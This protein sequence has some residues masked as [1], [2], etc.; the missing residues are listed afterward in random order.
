MVI[1][2]SETSNLEE[3]EIC[4]ILH[5][6]GLKLRSLLNEDRERKQNSENKEMM[7]H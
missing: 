2:F 4:K 5:L 1:N 3:K 7:T 6:H